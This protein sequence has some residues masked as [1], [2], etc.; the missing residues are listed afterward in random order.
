M[1]PWIE[2][3]IDALRALRGCTVSQWLGIEV[4]L[5][6]TGPDGQPQWY[7]PSVP[8]LQLDRLD[9]L[10]SDGS[11]MSIVT[12]Q[13]DVQCGLCRRD[14]LPPLEQSSPI[15]GSIFR[16]RTL[17]ELPHGKIASVDVLVDEI[18]DIAE[19][20][21]GLDDHEVL[22]RPGEVYEGP[23]GLLRIAAMDEGILVQVDGHR[24]AAG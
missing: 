16:L 15:S 4:A 14:A 18:G 8:A 2:Y 19:V 22:L 3:Q 10:L 20:R 9:L 11:V 21:F 13:N 7:D 5:R 24:P 1:I 17:N 23:D 12:Y 6:K